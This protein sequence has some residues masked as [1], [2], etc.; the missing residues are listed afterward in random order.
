MAHRPRPVRVTLPRL[1]A[2]KTHESTRK[3]AR[4]LDAGTARIL[5][6]T[7]RRQD[8][9]RR[10]PLVGSGELR[11]EAYLCSLTRNGSLGL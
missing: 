7:V 2:I 1:G 3:L 5:P 4:R 10:G 8:R 9:A 11:V 6:V